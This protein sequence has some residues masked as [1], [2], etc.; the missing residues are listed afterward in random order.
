MKNKSASFSK[1]KVSSLKESEKEVL[2][3]TVI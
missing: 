3:H 1:I 2:E